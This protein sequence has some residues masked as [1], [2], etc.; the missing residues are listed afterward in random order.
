V[1]VLLHCPACCAADVICPGCGQGWRYGL[2]RP[3][4]AFPAD[5]ITDA[6]EGCGMVLQLMPVGWASNP[7]GEGAAQLSPPLAAAVAGLERSWHRP[8][9][10]RPAQPSVTA[11]TAS[12]RP[13]H[14]KP[15]PADATRYRLAAWDRAGWLPAGVAPAAIAAAYR[16]RFGVE[17]RRDAAC[18]TS[19]AYSQR[20]LGMALGELGRAFA[21]KPLR[22]VG[23]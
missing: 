2:F 20:E 14:P 6:C 18:K 9:V 21:P 23:Q 8:P 15:C 10:D 3:P 12:S 16:R 7:T 19:R 4:A 22:E 17:P 11:V 5:P 13:P 1:E